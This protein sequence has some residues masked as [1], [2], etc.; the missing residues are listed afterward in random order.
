M[1]PCQPIKALLQ[2]SKTIRLRPAAL[3]IAAVL[4]VLVVLVQAAA[5][6]LEQNKPAFLVHTACMMP[7]TD[8]QTHRASDPSRQAGPV[9]ASLMGEA[10]L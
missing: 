10:A 1:Q 5:I 7:H 2:Q 4:L 3:L 6:R 9:P 8:A